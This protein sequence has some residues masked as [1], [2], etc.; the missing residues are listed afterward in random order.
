MILHDMR[1]SCVHRVVLAELPP[2][3]LPPHFQFEFLGEKDI[4]D[5]PSMHV[6][7]TAVKQYVGS[8]MEAPAAVVERLPAGTPLM[9]IDLV[10]N[11][12]DFTEMLQIMTEQMEF[13]NDLAPFSDWNVSKRMWTEMYHTLKG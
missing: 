4:G 12:V 13:M 9:F 10:Q 3:Y 1:T 5:C 2:V 11:D 7:Y 6:W 8:I